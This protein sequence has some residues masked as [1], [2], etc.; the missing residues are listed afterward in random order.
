MEGK[1]FFA[2]ERK[3]IEIQCSVEDEMEKNFKKFADKI[4]SNPNVFEFFYDDKKISKDSSILKLTKS[5]TKKEIIV[6]AE[7]ISTIIK[8]PACICNDAI[9]SIED[10]KLKFYGCKYGHNPDSIIIEDYDKS[11][12]I[13]F[14]K[15]KCHKN[16]CSY[17]QR[18]NPADFYKCLQCTKINKVTTYFCSDH[19]KQHNKQHKTIAYNEKNYCCESHFK[20]FT[21][22]CSK[23]DKNLCEDCE[24]SHKDKS[25]N[26][27]N[28]NSLTKDTKNIKDNLSKIKDTI[29]DL[30]CIVEKIKEYLDSSVRIFEKYYN[31]GQDIIYKYETYNK[32]LKNYR[33]LKSVL[34]LKDSNEKIMKDLD[35]IINGEKF[36]E[37]INRIINIYILDREDYTKGSQNQ[38]N[39]SI[40]N[41]DLDQSFKEIEVPL[42]N[43]NN[44]ENKISG[45]KKGKHHKKEKSTISN[46]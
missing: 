45:Q 21:K 12:K 15:I 30:K 9:L 24:S 11:Q 35:E 41:T 40:I 33:I 1:V 46:Q 8:C 38:N 37:Q 42:S 3:I 5:K 29:E 23:C 27:I 18:N 19:R 44:E 2:H 16:G 43:G 34:N 13:E 7:R 31:I 25:H 20:N 28:Y 6:T 36:M 22:Y 4:N 26:I 14:D 39:N 10:Y 17:N 32:E